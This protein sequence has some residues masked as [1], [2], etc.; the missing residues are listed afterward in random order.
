MKLENTQVGV[1][2]EY[3]VAAELSLRGY[4][5]SVTLRNTRGVDIIASTREG[6]KSVSIQV[7]TNNNGS[8]QWLLSEK[9]ESFQSSIHFYV[10]VS[11]KDLS[12]HPEYFV[13][14]SEVVAKK[15]K[16]DHLE[17]LNGTPRK[18]STRKETTMRKFILP[19]QNQYKD[20]W[21]ILFSD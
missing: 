1:A 12:K 14:P 3:F 15:I 7:K 4:I 13:V 19:P 10:F 17:W 6:T 9:S 5:A 18:G 11:M 8:T 20:N 2:G 21:S 16:K